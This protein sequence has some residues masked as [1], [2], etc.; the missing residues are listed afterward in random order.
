MASFRPHLA[1]TPL[2]VACPSPPSGWT[3]D[4]HPRVAKHARHT[5]KGARRSGGP[6]FTGGGVGFLGSRSFIGLVN[7]RFPL[8]GQDFSEHLRK[9]LAG[10]KIES[11]AS[12]RAYDLSNAR[13]A[14]HFS[15]SPGT[16]RAEA[17]RRPCGLLR[18]ACFHPREPLR[19]ARKPVSSDAFA[20]RYNH[21][22][23]IVETNHTLTGV[24]DDWSDRR[25]RAGRST[26]WR[27]TR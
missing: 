7:P 4:L 1:V 20:C 13:A 17:V 16:G 3:G 18:Q 23:I 15:T 9:W 24:L 6:P 8:T 14:E 26:V 19:P 10:K 5:K 12:D 22:R 11:T 21:A 2:P 25:Y 27:D